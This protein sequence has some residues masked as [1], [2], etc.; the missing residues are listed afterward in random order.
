MICRRAFISLCGCILTFSI[1]TAYR[2][3]AFLRP[4]VVRILDIHR[5]GSPAVEVDDQISDEEE[6]RGAIAPASSGVQEYVLVG[7]LNPSSNSTHRGAGEG[8]I[9]RCYETTHGEDTSLVEEIWDASS[10]SRNHLACAEMMGCL[11]RQVVLDLS[12]E[13]AISALNPGDGSAF[14]DDVLLLIAKGAVDQMK[15]CHDGGQ[16]IVSLSITLRG[17]VSSQSDVEQELETVLRSYFDR[18]LTRMQHRHFGKMPHGSD[19][20]GRCKSIVLFSADSR[21]D[22]ARKMARV[23]L[24]LANLANQVSFDQFE[25]YSNQ[26]YRQIGGDESHKLLKLS[27]SSTTL[28]RP[29]DL[30]K[31]SAISPELKLTVD[32]IKSTV[33]RRVADQIDELEERI[34]LS[35][36]GSNSLDS[37][38]AENFQ[39]H[40]NSILDGI[41]TMFGAASNELV[42]DLERNWV[43]AQRLDLMTQVARTEIS[44]LFR[45]QLDRLRDHFG[46]WY[47]SYLQASMGNEI[48]EGW[49]AKRQQAAKKAE[50]A[51][52]RAAF[53]AIPSSCQQPDGELWEQT[54]DVFGCLESLRGLLEDMYDATS[55]LGLEQEEWENIATSEAEIKGVDSLP[56]RKRRALRQVVKDIKQRLQQR[57][58]TKWYGRL[59]FKVVP[60]LVNYVQGWIILQ[61]LRREA[62]KRDQRM[63]KFPMF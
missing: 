41:S 21:M 26:L 16:M 43:N 51:F 25:L 29:D 1:A 6:P 36:G 19:E 13:Q 50:E 60:L 7:V 11:C 45:L 23:C 61:T 54:S 27:Q 37:N 63:P 20:F 18:A 17:N 22:T 58:P 33:Y 14:L 30:V 55:V 59:A 2:K 62:Q 39:V 38:P 35:E 3:Q 52:I 28:S 15:G 5:G 44:R 32:Q 53:G 48:D 56:T 12:Q 49:S 31:T 9:L 57:G 42:N 34:D 47:E 46:L 8:V 10:S 24:D 40:A 4:A